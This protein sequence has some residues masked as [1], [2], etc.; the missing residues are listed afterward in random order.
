MAEYESSIPAA[1]EERIAAFG[2]DGGRQRAEYW[3]DGA[4][5][6]V[7]EYFETGELTV[8][9]GLRDGRYHGMWYRWDL[10]G[11]LVSAIPYD[12]GLEHGTAR[13]WALS[14]ELLGSYTMQQGTG[15][16]LW[17]AQQPDGPRLLSEARYYRAGQRHGF[18]WWLSADQQSVY[19]EGHYADGAAH[20]I[21][22][23]WN[24][25][26]RLR[27]GFPQY[28]IQGTRVAK[29]AYLRACRHDPTL[30]PFRLEDNA[31]RRSFPAEVAA[32]LGPGVGR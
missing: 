5:V 26:G 29:R 21:L 27:R 22:R 25:H 17:W 10:P 20:G 3:F 28:M 12:A 15:L 6:G 30:P 9:F 4:L 31:P 18:E 19:E 7:R 2:P 24:R 32:Q 13:Q 23:Q 16:D 8:E 1:A 11:R 14:G